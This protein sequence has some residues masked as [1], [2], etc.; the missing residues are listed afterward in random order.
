M[1]PLSDLFN[2]VERRLADLGDIGGMFD[3]ADIRLFDKIIEKRDDLSIV[4]LGVEERIDQWGERLDAIEE[5]LVVLEAR[6]IGRLGEWG[7]RLDEIEARLTALE[8]G[9]E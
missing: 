5:Q 1:T 2:D 3:P 8:G 6:F 4:V 9:D 7:D